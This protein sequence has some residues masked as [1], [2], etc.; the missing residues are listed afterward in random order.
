MILYQGLNTH[1]PTE[2]L[3]L[4]CGFLL[5]FVSVALLTI[6]RNDD[7]EAQKGKRRTSSVDYERVNNFA[8]GGDE[9]DEV[10]LRSI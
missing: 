2:I 6:S 5:E 1:D 8:V 4:I 7:S 3:S 10:E 9:E